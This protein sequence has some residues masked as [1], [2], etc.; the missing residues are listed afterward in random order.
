MTLDERVAAFRAA[1]A[2]LLA[3]TQRWRA[4]ID[5]GNP[6]SR[7]ERLHTV[8]QIRT[9]FAA[10]MDNHPPPLFNGD[11]ENFK[12]ALKLWSEGGC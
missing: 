9:R 10:I 2:D 8:H 6:P 12:R 7:E 1:A 5:A 3:A 4:Q 11:I